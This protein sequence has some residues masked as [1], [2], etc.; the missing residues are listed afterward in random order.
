MSYSDL[1]VNYPSPHFTPPPS[2]L[3]LVDPST[4]SPSNKPCF[5]L[6]PLIV[7][8]LLRWATWERQ[9]FPCTL[10]LSWENKFQRLTGKEKGEGELRGEGSGV[11]KVR[12]VKEID[13]GCNQASLQGISTGEIQGSAQTLVLML[14]YPIHIKWGIMTSSIYIHI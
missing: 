6:L 11:Q 14:L 2:V 8:F 5:P 13:P 1:P 7:F 3:S 4:I 9:D 12:W 10:R